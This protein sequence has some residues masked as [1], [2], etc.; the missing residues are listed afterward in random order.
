MTRALEYAAQAAAV[1]RVNAPAA[2]ARDVL[3]RWLVFDHLLRR[4]SSGFRLQV[5]LH[6]F[7]GLETVFH[8]FT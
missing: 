6:S 3:S 2:A 7:R 8:T 5:A 4:Y 1:R